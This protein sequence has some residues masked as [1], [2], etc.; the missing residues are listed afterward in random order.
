MPPVGVTSYAHAPLLQTPPAASLQSLLV[1]QLLVGK[2]TNSSPPW[3]AQ[4]PRG[5][6]TVAWNTSVSH[7][8]TCPPWDPVMPSAKKIFSPTVTAV[9]QFGGS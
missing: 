8:V 3:K 2:R 5:S 6:D 1:V 9:W 7:G 4:L